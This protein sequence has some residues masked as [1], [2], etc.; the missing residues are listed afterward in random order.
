M[1][2]WESSKTQN[3]KLTP[4]V[5]KL[6]I[7][8]F[9]EFINEFS[10]YLKKNN[11]E[12][13]GKLQPLG[14]TSYVQYDIDN[15]VDKVYGDVD[16]MV[17]IPIAVEQKSDYRKQENIIK[18]KYINAFISFVKTHTVKNVVVADT[19]HT[20]AKSIIFDLGKNMYSQVDLIWTFKPY[21]KWMAGRY[22]P[23]YG[24]KGFNI[25]NLYSALGAV[26]TLSF[27][28]EGVMGRFKNNILVT[29]K[30]RKGV[31][32]KLISTD[33]GKFILI[34]IKFLIKLNTPSINI[35]DIQI[36]PLLKKYKGIDTNNVSIKNFCLAIRGMANTLEANDVLGVGGLSNIKSSKIF[37]QKIRS[38]YAKRMKKQ[39]D[40]NN[41]KYKKATS[42]EAI[43]MVKD[44]RKNAM[45]AIGIVNKYLR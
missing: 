37:I 18:R 38:E 11:L 43:Q 6:S 24:L 31:E 5:A 34:A 27:G 35:K 32:Y 12:P 26:V 8:V 16:M 25:G 30:F 20:N 13:I 23:E 10:K 21:I 2:G 9:T 33:I 22:K 17:E 29:S 1:G 45:A 28:T 7:K 36:D 3:T 15:D 39:I 4:K 42:P 14:S 41:P 40:R 19:L 44:T